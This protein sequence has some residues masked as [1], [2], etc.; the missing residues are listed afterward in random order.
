MIIILDVCYLKRHSLYTFFFEMIQFW[1]ICYT[2]LP[3]TTIYKT[4]ISQKV[5]QIVNL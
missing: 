3:Q 2:N 5:F 4:I 1:H